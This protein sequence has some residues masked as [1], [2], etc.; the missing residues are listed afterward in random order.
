MAE[1]C[2]DCWNRFNHTEKTERDYV[3]SRTPSLCEGCRQWK[4]VIVKARQCKALYDVLT[5]C[6]M[7][8]KSVPRKDN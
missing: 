6:K 1:Y 7:A 4:P 8:C 3:L 2:L 5:T